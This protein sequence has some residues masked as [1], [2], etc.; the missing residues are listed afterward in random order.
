ML[1]VMVLCC[2]L[3]VLSCVGVFCVDVEMLSDS[4]RESVRSLF[5]G[6]GV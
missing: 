2:I 5:I 4:S 1:V 6:R 3:M